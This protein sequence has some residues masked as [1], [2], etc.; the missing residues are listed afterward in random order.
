MKR[1]SKS[2]GRALVCLFLLLVVHSAAE[3]QN[4][5]VR[6]LSDVSFGTYDPLQSGNLDATGL[7]RLRCSPPASNVSVKLGTGLGGGYLEVTIPHPPVE[8]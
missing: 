3:A 2:L 6:V 5:R 7:L 1:C 8:R 4:C